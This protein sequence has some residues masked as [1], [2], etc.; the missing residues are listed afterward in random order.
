[1]K[2]TIGIVLLVIGLIFGVFALTTHEEDKTLLD[3]GK[4]EIKK[5][6]K[7]PSN[8]TTM[9]YVIAGI[10]VIAGGAMLAGKKS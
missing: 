2:R 1:M 3:L 8:N 10:C 5:Q 6:D 4:I 9:Y 7:S